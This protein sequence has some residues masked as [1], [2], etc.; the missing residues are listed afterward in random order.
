MY[1]RHSHIISSFFSQVDP[2]KNKAS[3]KSLSDEA[4]QI[5]MK[6]VQVNAQVRAVI[7][8]LEASYGII[9]MF[10]LSLYTSDAADE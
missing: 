1:C 7:S 3:S 8:L 10:L 5:N 6:K 9:S 2:S 4:N